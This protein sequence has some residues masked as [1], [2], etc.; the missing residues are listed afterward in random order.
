MV[1]AAKITLLLLGTLVLAGG[2]FGF[3]R[4]K[5]KASLIAGI[6]TA[7]LFGISFGISSAN[8]RIGLILGDLVAFMLFV[9]GSIRYRKTKKYMPGLLIMGLGCIGLVVITLALVKG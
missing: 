7:L 6:V 5:S 9:V 3:V 4:R 8:E 1:A 2:I